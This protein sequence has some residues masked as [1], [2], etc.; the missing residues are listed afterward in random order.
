[1]VDPRPTHPL[2]GVADDSSSAPRKTTADDATTDPGQARGGGSRVTRTWLAVGAAG[3]LLMT[4]LV[5]GPAS[6]DDPVV[7]VA[8]AT[9]L[10]AT[11]EP[12]T[13][14]SA[15]TTATADDGTP[16]ID[17]GDTA[18][19][20]ATA[21]M[22]EGDAGQQSADGGPAAAGT[23]DEPA[24]GQRAD[25]APVAQDAAGNQNGETA[26]TTE[27]EAD[28]TDTGEDG[29]ESQD[30]GT[31][32]PAI[33]FPVVGPT[34]YV[35]TWGACR[36]T[37]CSRGHKGVDI[38]AHKLAPLVA[39]ADGVITAD[40]RS[41]MGL[42]GNTVIIT[43]DNGWRYLYI[44][45][46][47]DSPGTDDGWNPQ[48][49]I[50]PN[51]LRV[52]DRVEA[53]QVIGYVGD[54]GNAETTPSHVHFELHRPGVGAINPTPAVLLAQREE[55]V[56]PVAGLA[57]TGEGRAEYGPVVSA[58]YRALLK[59]EPTDKELFAW[60]DRFDIGFATTDDLIADLTMAKPRRDPAGNV[61]RA[62]RVSLDRTP[63]LNEIRLWEEAYRNG[64]D[65]DGI[66]ST[67]IDSAPFRDRHGELS[68]EEFIKV[69]YRNAIG[70][71]PSPQRLDD[72][73]ALFAE[74]SPRSE[75]TA[76]WADSY[77]VKNSTWH[78]LE[79]IQ[80]FRAA[81]DRM[82]TDDEYTQWVAHLDGGGLTP[83]VVDA[84]RPD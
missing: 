1:M 39:A 60:T 47:N 44:H 13:T 36:G 49:W 71:E 14:D 45:L 73:L 33:V 43:D 54:S 38:F 26:E 27:N 17:Q 76:Y 15:E 19:E 25:G 67:L 5:V 51:R 59:R 30:D 82:P 55:R 10:T 7:E 9:A 69:I 53:G 29:G 84:I 56:I 65:L 18:G 2:T 48:G 80:S 24:E 63:T 72:W 21:P 34:S 35:D 31:A 6:A 16:Q 28:T 81:A 12:A 77:S 41:A 50:L 52:G 3:A 42:S 61:V 58:W 8:G 75:L 46:N 32:E 40:R 66:T 22:Q 57:S 62:F 74:G 68:D 70:V 83:D 78:G 4:A 20:P 23:G 11:E 37:R 64:T 79:V